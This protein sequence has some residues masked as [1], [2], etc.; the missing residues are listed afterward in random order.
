MAENYEE[1]T[2]IKIMKGPFCTLDSL[3]GLKEDDF[4]ISAEMDLI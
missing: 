4:L 2:F 1:K 3:S